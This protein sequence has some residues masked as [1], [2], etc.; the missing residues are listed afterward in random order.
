[1]AT[2]APYPTPVVTSGSYRLA[3]GL[4]YSSVVVLADL[5]GGG[6]DS[7]DPK[8]YLNVGGTAVPIQ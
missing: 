3:R 6:G 4:R 1:M 2:I 7:V 8:R 5:T